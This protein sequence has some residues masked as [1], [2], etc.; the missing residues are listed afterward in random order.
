MAAFIVADVVRKLSG[1]FA[2]VGGTGGK[3]GPAQRRNIDQIVSDEA[4][5]LG[6]QACFGGDSVQALAQPS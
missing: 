4:N 3:P 2:S 6:F 5:L 1:F